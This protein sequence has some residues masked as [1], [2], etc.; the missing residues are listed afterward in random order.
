M[1]WKVWVNGYDNSFVILTRNTPNLY[2]VLF[3]RLRNLALVVPVVFA[4]V[5]WLLVDFSVRMELYQ[6]LDHNGPKV[7]VA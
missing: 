1:C 7:V 2:G 3:V 6:V 4:V 5:V